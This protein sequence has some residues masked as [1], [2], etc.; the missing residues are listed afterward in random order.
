[1]YREGITKFELNCHSRGAFHPLAK[2]TL[3][4]MLRN[5]R[6]SQGKFCHLQCTIKGKLVKGAHAD[7]RPWSDD[8]LI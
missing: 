3:I 1:M 4:K 8:A 2:P 7:S 6:K 5:K